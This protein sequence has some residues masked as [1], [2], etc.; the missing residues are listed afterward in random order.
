MIIAKTITE[1]RKIIAHAHTTGK[2]IGLVPTMGALHDGHLSLIRACRTQCDYTVVSIF[3]NPTQFGPNED[4]DRYPRTFDADSAACE[5]LNVDLIFA[6]D[7]NEM[8]PQQNLTWIIPEKLGDHLC[9]ASRPGFFR[10]VCTVVS[11]LFH[12][13]QPDVAY[14]GRKD[15][16]QL[17]VIRHM[18]AD[19]NFPV[20]IRPIDTV[21]EPDGLAMS[22]RNAYLT[23]EQRI[24]ASCLYQALTLARDLITAGQ[25]NP[26]TIIQALK[27]RIENQPDTKIDY[28]S[29]VDNDLMHPVSTIDAPV[30]IALA[31]HLG[32]ARLIDNIMVDPNSQKP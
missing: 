3:V 11:K 15:A 26:D 31:V 8:Y 27:K 10:G 30:T 17:A 32:P 23:P 19:L 2:S 14:F 12:I 7:T 13:I 9:G 21:R 25:K 28:I 20:E 24:Q 4:C 29:I 6:P 16:Q 1:T 18:V 5:K 22:S